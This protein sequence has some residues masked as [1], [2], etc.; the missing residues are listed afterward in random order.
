ML[1]FGIQSINAKKK[2]LTLFFLYKEAERK[3]VH[4]AS[5]CAA[6]DVM[7]VWPELQA[8]L[9]SGHT[10]AAKAS[11]PTYL[12]KHAVKKIYEMFKE[13]A[14]LKKIKANVAVTLLMYHTVRRCKNFQIGHFL[15]W[16]IPI[17]FLLM[18]M[19]IL[20]V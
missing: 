13:W 5:H 11:I 3:A 10:L 1:T 8:I 4:D 20:N 16:L 6:E 18:K 19:T 12:K 17:Y 9:S 2:V 7:K 14:K 15:L